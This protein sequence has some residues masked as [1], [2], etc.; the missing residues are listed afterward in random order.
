MDESVLKRKAPQSGARRSEP[1][2]K[3]EARHFSDDL[4]ADACDPAVAWAKT[5]PSLETAWAVCRRGD[6]MLWWLAH[7]GIDRRQLVKTAALCAEPAA[8]L[9]GEDEGLC[10]SAVQT[11]IAW[12]EREATDEEL[13]TAATAATA[14]AAE[15][16]TAE[17][18]TAAAWA[19]ARAA[20]GAEWAA[21]AAEWAAWAA[22]WAAW[23][24][25]WAAEAAARAAEAAARAAEAGADAARVAS[26]AH[27][28][29]I[30]RGVFPEPPRL[31]GES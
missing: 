24:A 22:E 19:A 1:V 8:A 7:C 15:A 18:A 12:S 23:A 9:A 10:L 20:E 30:V 28:A 2:L 17:A 4:P 6:W 3:R 14:E 26:L 25:E 21:R 29:D 31:G 27:S 5:Q 11:C 16:A 13:A